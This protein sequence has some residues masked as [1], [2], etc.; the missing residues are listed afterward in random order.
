MVCYWLELSISGLTDSPA[1]TMFRMAP[2]LL[3]LWLSSRSIPQPENPGILANPAPCERGLLTELWWL[4]DLNFSKRKRGRPWETYFWALT[5]PSPRSGYPR[6]E[7]LTVKEAAQIPSFLKSQEPHAAR[8]HAATK[9]RRKH[10]KASSQNQQTP[11]ALPR[12]WFHSLKRWY[13]VVLMHHVVMLHDVASRQPVVMITAARYTSMGPPPRLS[14]SCPGSSQT[15]VL[16]GR[17]KKNSSLMTTENLANPCKSP[18][19]ICSYLFQWPRS[20]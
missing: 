15:S 13:R 9:S 10:Q 2:A 19:L 20:E 18:V 16:T 5:L 3:S 14:L 17:S 7:I 1:L 6:T 11:K 8:W 12:T 4:T